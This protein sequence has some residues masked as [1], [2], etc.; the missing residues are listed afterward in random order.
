[1]A[2]L[3]GAA[4]EAQRLAH[5]GR[6]QFQ[7]GD[8]LTL[9]AALPQADVV[10][11]DR[12]VCCDPDYVRMLRAAAGRARRL[13]AF[14]Y[15]RPRWVTRLM[16]AGSNAVRRLLGNDFRAYVH[17]PAA[18]AAVLEEAGLRRSWTG[19]TWIWAVEVFER[20]S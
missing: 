16:V 8:F 5:T 13:V 1:A 19:G 14:S 18:M 15:P 7:S 2:Y 12:V 11:L 4:D 20:A 9:A 3:A 6:V 17:A 10:T